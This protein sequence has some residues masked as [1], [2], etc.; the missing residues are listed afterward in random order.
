[1]ATVFSLRRIA[2]IALFASWSAVTLAAEPSSSD[3]SDANWPRFRGPG[4]NGFVTAGEAFPLTCD[5][6]T[7]ANIAWSVEIPAPG[8]SS[9]VVWGNRLFL[10]GGDEKKR[11][12]MCFDTA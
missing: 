3:N 1:M 6:K 2:R 5:P 10:T 9:P 12:V 7:G 4:G 11:C 8:Y